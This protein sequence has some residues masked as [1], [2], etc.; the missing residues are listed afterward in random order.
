MYYVS[1]D[2]IFPNSLQ[3]YGETERDQ[4]V[5]EWPGQVV[6]CCSQVFWTVEVHEAIR[7]GTAV[8]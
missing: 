1:E 6:L 5:K 2:V 7:E 8:R 4:W 3:A